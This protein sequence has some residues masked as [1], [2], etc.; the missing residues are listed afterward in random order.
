MTKRHDD[1]FDAVLSG[2]TTARDTQSAKDKGGARFLKRGNA[3][4][5]RLAGQ[6]EEKLLHWVE[7][8]L[9]QMWARHNRDYALLNEHNCSDL[10]EGIRAQG[11]QEFPA[12]VRRIEGADFDYEVICGARRHFAISWLRAHNYAQFKYLVEVRDLSDEEAFRLADIENRDRE[13][14]SDYERAIDYAA[15]VTVYYGG[16]QKAMA[17]RLEVSEV[18]LSRY[19]ELARLPKEIVAAYASIRDIRE[20]HARTLKPLLKSP[21]SRA[22]V[23]AIA[24]DLGVAQQSAREG[25]GAFIQAQT[26]I[27]SL[28]ASA[29]APKTKTV[30]PKL[31]SGGDGKPSVQHSQKGR[32]HKLEF[33]TGISQQDFMAAVEAFSKAKL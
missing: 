21:E 27:N 15:A 13:D 23:L 25:Q 14:I 10:I 33:A 11:Q 4:S 8:E 20:L 9:C 19:L 2:V 30:L 3:I 12:I 16:K 1:I 22:K 31:Y 29:A 24:Y 32:T 26:V 7:P 17:E 5:E 28:K 6:S 18:W